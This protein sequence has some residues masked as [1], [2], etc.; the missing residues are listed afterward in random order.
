M[1]S[2]VTNATLKDAVRLDVF[3]PHVLA[4]FDGSIDELIIVIDGLREAG[5]ISRLHQS[6]A[7]ADTITPT[8]LEKLKTTDTRIK[9]I[10]CDYSQVKSISRKWFNQP[11]VIR[12]QDGT[13]IFAFLFGIEQ[14]KNEKIIRSDCDMFFYENGF[15]DAIHQDQETDIM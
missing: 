11:E 3:V 12:C 8:Y 13:P 14:C 1:V 6:E 7:I 15:L 9:I 10:N 4:V 2:F 5:R